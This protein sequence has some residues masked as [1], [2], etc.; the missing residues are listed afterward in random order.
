MQHEKNEVS[1]L[2]NDMAKL[3]DLGE[4]FF[5]FNPDSDQTLA[6]RLASEK[7]TNYFLLSNRTGKLKK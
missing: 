3:W 7:R 1:S 4:I 2:D 6:V 5:C